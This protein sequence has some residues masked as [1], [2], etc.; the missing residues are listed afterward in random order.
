M[1]EVDR[2]EVAQSLIQQSQHASQILAFLLQSLIFLHQ[3]FRESLVVDIADKH[4]INALHR[5]VQKIEGYTL[6]ISN[7]GR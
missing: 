6:V 4:V 1:G 2:G 3:T 7:E 5:L